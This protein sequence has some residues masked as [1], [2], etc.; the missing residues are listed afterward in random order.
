MVD[1]VQAV[2]SGVNLLWLKGY[3]HAIESLFVKPGKTLGG[4]TGFYSYTKF[5]ET[6]L[7]IHET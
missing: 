1:N 6:T 2:R 3:P 4:S 7:R 5:K